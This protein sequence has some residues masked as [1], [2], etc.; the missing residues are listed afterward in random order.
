MTVVPDSTVP[1]GPGVLPPFA[2]PP[3]DGNLRRMWLGLVIGFVVLVVCC[4]AGAAGL[5]VLGGGLEASVRGKAQAVVSEY[6]IDWQKGDY[7]GAYQLLCA[8]DQQS[9]SL[10]AF[11][12]QLEQNQ[13]ESFRVG[14][15]VT[16]SSDIAVPVRA[17]YTN[18]ASRTSNYFVAIEGDGNAYLCGN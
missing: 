4:G 5:V 17:T 14:T 13:V 9:T 8:E 3:S 2:A 7:P 1:A 18:G 15:A 12:S 10:S 16:T 6:M 11:S